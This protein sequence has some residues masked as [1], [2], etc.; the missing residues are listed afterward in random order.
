[1]RF[2][3]FEALGQGLGPVDNF[4]WADPNGHGMGLSATSASGTP[5]ASG[6]RRLPFSW[7]TQLVPISLSTAEQQAL[8]DDFKQAILP[9]F[10]TGTT[11]LE[12]K[13][14]TSNDELKRIYLVV[15][16]T[17][18][19]PPKWLLGLECNGACF[20]EDHQPLMFFGEPNG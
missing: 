5:D 19:G 11:I 6:Q 10:L 13:A 20:R 14:M 17:K 15:P 2:K 8:R 4:H 9:R 16:D 7:Y 12:L 3:C 18:P 1:M